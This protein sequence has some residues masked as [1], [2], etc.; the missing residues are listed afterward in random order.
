MSGE[1]TAAP[2]RTST[3]PAQTVVL[4][5]LAVAAVALGGLVGLAVVVAVAALRLSGASPAIVGGLGVALLVAAPLVVVGNGLPSDAQVSPGIVTDTLLPHHLVFA[6]L[7]LVSVWV[8][9]DVAPRRV[10]EPGPEV[11]DPGD[12]PGG[13]LWLRRVVFA[14]VVVAAVAASVAVLQA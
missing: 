7:A 10:R 12:G 8:V 14:L 4:I 2:V 3:G 11:T 6:G 1:A 5:A 9:F 13:P